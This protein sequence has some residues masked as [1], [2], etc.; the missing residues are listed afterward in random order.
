MS[1][2]KEP[3]GAGV[4]DLTAGQ[5]TSKLVTPC[6]CQLVD[7]NKVLVVHVHTQKE[8]LRNG[9]IMQADSC[10]LFKIYT[11]EWIEMAKAAKEKEKTPGAERD[12][13]NKKKAVARSEVRTI[14]R[15]FSS[16]C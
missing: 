1:S 16:S 6:P 4:V 3:K 9:K 15:K 13:P 7:L 8:S 11:D 12:N 2:D 5:T 10:L 14:L